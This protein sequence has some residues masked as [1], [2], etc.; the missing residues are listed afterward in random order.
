MATLY[1]SSKTARKF[2][3]FF[4]IGSLA[5]FI[6]QSIISPAPPQIAETNEGPGFYMA[7]NPIFGN[8]TF[9]EI[10]SIEYNRSVPII[11]EG[12][13][14]NFPETA[15]VYEIEQPREKLTTF[16]QAI[17][18]AETLGFT[19]E[20]YQESGSILSWEA[21]A[22]TK[23]LI[24]NLES[25][26][27]ELRTDY[28]ENP[29]ALRTKTLTEDLELYGDQVGR[30]MNRINISSNGLE[31]SSAEIRYA[32]QGRDGIFTDADSVEEAEYVFIDAY[33]NIRLADTNTLNPP[34]LE[35]GQIAPQPVDAFVYKNDPR[36]GQ[37]AV[38][39][40]N[41]LSDF[42][43]EIFE[44]D[45][46]N[47]TYDFVNRGA[48][49]IITPDEAVSAVQAGAGHLVYVNPQGVDTFVDP[50]ESYDIVDIR[51]EAPRTELAYLEPDIWEGFAYP[52]Y[53]F[54]GKARLSNGSLAD[55][56]I[57]VDAIK[58]A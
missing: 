24:I 2:V 4:I 8:I 6:L 11:R 36:D 12:V 20:Q 22:G 19:S 27:W 23:T 48:Y 5:I 53:V 16:D 14:P 43:R 32:V 45:F 50:E 33:R 15:Y 21:D 57:Y 25:Q 42:G 30:L 51:V 37:F 46:I 40:T 35:Q 58:R 34:E 44:I 17:F 39:A 54:R 49:P 3:I 52:M 56:V 47:Y 28:S 10:R 29:E 18:A 31:N 26:A 13:F 38:V 1:E 7:P 55:F 9:P 41:F